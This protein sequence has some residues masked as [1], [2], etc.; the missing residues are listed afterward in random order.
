M[1]KK[2]DNQKPPEISDQ[3]D[4][5]N[6]SFDDDDD[7][8][9]N[10]NF[11]KKSDQF[12][13]E[14]MFKNSTLTTKSDNSSIIQSKKLDPDSLGAFMDDL[15][16]IINDSPSKKLKANQP[17]AQTSVVKSLVFDN[18]PTAIQV[19]QKSDNNKVDPDSI[20]IIEKSE[21]IDDLE[22]EI[23]QLV[24][25]KNQ[26]KNTPAADSAISILAEGLPPPGFRNS[27]QTMQAASG[28]ITI[29]A[30][31]DK[32]RS[33]PSSFHLPNNKDDAPSLSELLKSDPKPPERKDSKKKDEKDK[34]KVQKDDISGLS[35]LLRSEIKSESKKGVKVKKDE[36]PGLSQ[37]LRDELH[38]NNPGKYFKKYFIN[39]ITLN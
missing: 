2:A 39:F 28:E 15:D 10:L 17:L 34:K 20:E 6:D 33:K 23:N 31:I 30:D 5:D 18:L 3:S 11:A 25:S 1:A 22:N 38:T 9:Q 29:D 37:L 19:N 13:N 24:N 12:S 32:N 14:N 7:Y 27:E 8:M 16:N 36:I 26:S 21:S 35:D 4:I